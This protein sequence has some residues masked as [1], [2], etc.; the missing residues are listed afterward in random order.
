M[1]EQG[2]TKQKKRKNIPEEG[3]TMNKNKPS[4][5]RMSCEKRETARV[6][7]REELGLGR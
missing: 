6:S 1:N 7:G 4:L 5:G 2:Y 3:N